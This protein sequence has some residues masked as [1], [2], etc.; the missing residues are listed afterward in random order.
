MRLHAAPAIPRGRV[1]VIEDGEVVADGRLSDLVRTDGDEAEN[2]DVYVN[3]AD[4]EGFRAR[5]FE[6]VE[7]SKGRLN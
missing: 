3:P 4:A 7:S 1:I 5:W 2:V 6:C